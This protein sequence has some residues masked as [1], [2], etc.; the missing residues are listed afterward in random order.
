MY[1]LATK[2]SPC[3]FSVESSSPGRAVLRSQSIQI[4]SAGAFCLEHS[5]RRPPFTTLHNPSSYSN[6]HHHHHPIP[7]VL[8]RAQVSTSTY[9]LADAI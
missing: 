1:P 5:G 8:R 2:E 6:K 3:L 7:A 9:A 4:D